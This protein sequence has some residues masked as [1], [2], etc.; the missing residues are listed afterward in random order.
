MHY[1]DAAVLLHMSALADVGALLWQSIITDDKII[2]AIQLCHCSFNLVDGNC[3]LYL[4]YRTTLVFLSI[5]I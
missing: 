1:I 3:C 5:E 2:Y 4:R